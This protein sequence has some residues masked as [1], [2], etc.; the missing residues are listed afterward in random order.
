MLSLHTV[1]FACLP[2][3][4]FLTYAPYIYEGEK[5]RNMFDLPP[6]FY[7]TEVNEMGTTNSILEDILRDTAPGDAILEAVRAR[8]GEVLRTASR[9]PGALRTYKSGSVAHRT[10][11]EDTDA[12]GGVV[13]DRRSY[14]SLGP[15]GDNGGPTEIVEDM[16]SYLRDELKD[17]HADV[18]FYVSKRAIRI[19]FKEPLS[20][21]TTDPTVD[22]I[23]ALTRKDGALW[24]PNLHRPGWDAS[25]PEFHTSLMTAEPANLRRTRAKIIRLA[26]VWNKQASKP[27]LCSFNITALALA[28]ITEG[29][30]IATG[31]AV[32]FDYAANDLKRHFTPDP[33]GVSPPIKLLE[34]RDVVIGRLERATKKMDDALTH[35]DDED[36]VREALSSLYGQYVD[37]PTGSSSKAAFASALRK[38]NSSVGI[39]GG[40]II[41]TQSKVPLKTTRSYGSGHVII[42]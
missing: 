13:L 19:T 11:N 36:A 31:L 6:I 29:M 1:L 8:H 16:R 22:L 28:C 37:P 40:L 34:D 12:D 35:D 39:S 38:G 23:V 10:A 18:A 5:H 27:G 21:G 3:A 2:P 9:Y 41:G 4:R 17:D 32:F 33:A 26:K 15:D 14:T 42:R 20:D 25:D 7:I 30:G 24:I